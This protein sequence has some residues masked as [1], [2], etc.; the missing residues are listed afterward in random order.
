MLEL[1]DKQLRATLVNLPLEM[2]FALKSGID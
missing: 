2:Y 1:S